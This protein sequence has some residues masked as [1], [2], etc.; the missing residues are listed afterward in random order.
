MVNSVDGLV[1]GLD[2]STIVSQLLQLERAPQTR[3]KTRQ[4]SLQTVRP[5]TGA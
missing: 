2:T 3:L 1:S 5:P 4:S